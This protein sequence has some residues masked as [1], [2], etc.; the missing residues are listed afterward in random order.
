MQYGS[1]TSQRLDDLTEREWHELQ[2]LRRAISDSPS[3]VHPMKMERFSELFARS[4]AGKGDR[5]VYDGS[6]AFPSTRTSNGNQ[7]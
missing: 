6:E 1:A 4:L 7:C 3:S 2:V 5:M